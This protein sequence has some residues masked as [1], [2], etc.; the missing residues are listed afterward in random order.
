MN[1]ATSKKEYIHRINKVIDY[2]ERNMDTQLNVKSIA[3]VACFSPFHF[4]RIF[5]AFKGE[6]LNQ[7]L[8]RKRIEKAAS[9]LLQNKET[10]VAEIAT[11]VGFQ[12]D[13][14]FCR[15][16]KDYFNMSAQAFRANWDDIKLRKNNQFNSKNDKLADDHTMYFGSIENNKIWREIMDKK[17]EIKEMPELKL[18]YCRHVGAFDGIGR[19][20]DKLAHWAGPR[21]LFNSHTKGVTVYHDNPSVTEIEKLQQ[22]ACFTVDRE[23]VTEGEIGFMTMPGGTHL[24]G[25]FEV[26]AQEFELAWKAVCMRLAESGYQPRDAFPYEL[27]HNNHEE[28]PERKFILDICVPV[29]PM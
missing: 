12:S 25:S 17:I 14:V 23:V 4:H 20:Y 10:P 26:N 28:H 15:S 19:A 27:Y 1:T 5:T 7:F 24:V 29:K 13:S 8:K 16:F 9:L 11:Y 2:I 3:E 6:T 22:S 21:G 18:I